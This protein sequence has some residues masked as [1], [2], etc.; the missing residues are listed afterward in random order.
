MPKWKA[1]YPNWVKFS[2]HFWFLRQFLR[3]AGIFFLVLKTLFGPFIVL[4]TNV[5]V[6]WFRCKIVY[7]TGH[8]GPRYL[9]KKKMGLR[10]VLRA[11]FV[12]F[13]QISRHMVVRFSNRSFHWNCE[14]ERVILS[15]IICTNGVFKYQRKI[16]MSFKTR[17]KNPKL[18]ENLTWLGKKAFHLGICDS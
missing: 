2:R 18:Q 16:P 10:L 7:K 3:L 6:P 8:P 5:S 11:M 14:I 13:L 15:T 12:M 1:F 9:R 4:K 17:L